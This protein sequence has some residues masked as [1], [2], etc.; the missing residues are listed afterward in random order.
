[1]SSVGSNRIECTNP[2]SETGNKGGKAWRPPAAKDEG[3]TMTQSTLRT[4]LC[5]TTA[6]GITLRGF[7]LVKELMGTLSFAEVLYLL[8]TGQK[9]TPGQARVLDATL[10]TLMDHGLTPHAI[11]ARMVYLSAPDSLQGAMAAGLLGV[12]GQFAGTMEE[13]ARLLV[14]IAAAETPAKADAEAE[15]I[16]ADYRARRASVP[17]FGH[18]VHRPDDPRS[19]R[20]FAIAAE[21]GC[22]GHYIA[23]LKRFSAVIDRLYGKHLTINATGAIAAVLL[24]I[25]IPAEIMRGVAVI[26][27]A[28]G[29]LA[30]LNEE[31]QTRLAGGLLHLVETSVAYDGP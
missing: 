24:E 10:V 7:D 8:I 11:A 9:A 22:P 28:G 5:K 13:S 21:A 19:P 30:Q 17:G 23:A 2:V 16:V 12:G 25:G 26:S 6:D 20:L 27:R 14:R 31:R 29:L 3:G 18:P 1:M 4:A 15:A